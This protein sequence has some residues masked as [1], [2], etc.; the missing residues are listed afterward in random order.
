MREH[1]DFNRPFETAHP[2]AIMLAM[3]ALAIPLGFG[4]DYGVDKL[5]TALNVR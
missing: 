2:A 4:L 3:V 1:F 5:V